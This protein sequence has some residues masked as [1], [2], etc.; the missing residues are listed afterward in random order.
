MP[1]FGGIGRLFAATQRPGL[2]VR[3]HIDVSP[4]DSSGRRDIAGRIISD[5]VATL[6]TW[7]RDQAKLTLDTETVSLELYLTDSFWNFRGTG[8]VTIKNS[9]QRGK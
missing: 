8:D 5:D 2:A 4:P 7:L 9:S 6:G 1:R 3:F